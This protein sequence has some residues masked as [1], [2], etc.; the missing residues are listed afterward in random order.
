[1]PKKTARQ[2]RAVAHRQDNLPL[3]I[4]VGVIAVVGVLLLVVLNMNLDT[5]AS[6]S[7]AIAGTGK[8]WG[9]DSAPVTIEMYSDFQ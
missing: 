6:S 3:I 9:K 7:S 1:M 4:G 5:R 8:M 2:K